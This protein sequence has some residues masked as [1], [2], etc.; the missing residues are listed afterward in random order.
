M[1]K[2]RPAEKVVVEASESTM[3]CLLAWSWHGAGLLGLI[4]MDFEEEI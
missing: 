3:Y 4:S 2:D 1:T